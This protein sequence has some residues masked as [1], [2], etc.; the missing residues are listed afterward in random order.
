MV[1]HKKY[2]KDTTHFPNGG[3]ITR[4][5]QVKEKK[6]QPI[7]VDCINRDNFQKPTTLLEQLFGK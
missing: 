6:P 2:Y 3:S 5:I 7:I 4:I 1:K